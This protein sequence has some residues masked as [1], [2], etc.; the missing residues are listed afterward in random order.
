ML[1][2]TVVSETQPTCC[3]H[4]VQDRDDLFTM[5]IR[6]ALPTTNIRQGHDF[7]H[8]K[9]QTVT[10]APS[11][12]RMARTQSMMLASSSGVVSKKVVMVR[13]PTTSS[14]KHRALL[15]DLEESG[16]HVGCEGQAL[17]SWHAGV[18]GSGPHGYHT[19]A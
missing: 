2:D 11:N 3:H 18:Q 7:L 17:K 12:M 8:T 14:S 5:N 19:P 9:L 4:D 13:S 1:H 10:H 16:Q 15:E 6:S